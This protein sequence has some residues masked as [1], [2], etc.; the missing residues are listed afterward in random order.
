ML[1]MKQVDDRLRRLS[2]RYTS[3][4]SDVQDMAVAIVAHANDTGDCDRARKL[5]RCLPPKLR[6]LLTNWF[7]EVSP[8]NVKMG[9]TA[10]EDTVSLRREGKKNYNPFDIEKAKANVWADDPFKK[11]PAPELATIATFTAS[12]ERLFDKIERDTK[13]D[14]GKVSPAD[15]ERV[16]ALRAHMRAAFVAFNEAHPVTIYDDLPEQEQEE[17]ANPA[18]AMAANA[19]NA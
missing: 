14:A 7:T 19:A 12:F 18:E 16:K 9:K 1:T 5:V 15:I 2:G 10:A 17:E 6:S 4:N 13:D 11:E 8:I 3:L